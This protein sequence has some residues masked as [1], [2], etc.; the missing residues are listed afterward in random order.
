MGDGTYEADQP[1]GEVF[2]VSRLNREARYLLEAGFSSVRVEGELSN[3]AR[4]GSGHMYFTLKDQGA[5]LRCAMFRQNNQRLTFRPEDGQA[6]VCR[7]RLSI[8]E[9]RGEYQ[10][11]VEAMAQAGEGDLQREFERLKKKLAAEGLFAEARK[12][13]PPPLPSRIGVITSPTGAAVRDILH[14]L[15][16]RFPAV[17]VRIYPVPVQGEGAAARIVAA[18]RNAGRRADCDVLILARGGGSM[19]DLWAFNEEILARAVYDSPIP[20]ITGIGHEIDFTIADFVADLRAPTPSGAAELAVPDGAEWLR[21][22]EVLES[23]LRALVARALADRGQKLG[24]T[25][26]RLRRLHP[27]NRLRQQAQRLDELE[28]RLGLACRGRIRHLRT[29]LA[30]LAGEFKAASPRPMIRAAQERLHTTEGR[31][32]SATRRAI[33]RY[34]GR[35]EVLAKTLQ[36]VGPEA[37]LERGYAIV[38]LPGDQIVRDRS[39]VSVGQDVSVRVAVGRFSARVTDDDQERS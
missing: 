15:A 24:W 30:A 1:G 17:P 16:R 32:R 28:Q 3:L 11:I 31:L 36:A 37:T 29:H 39:Q 9:M 27:G 25:A 13:R 4:P 34:Q 5:Q 21:R 35:L 2:T 18:V 8:Y 20:I 19:E 33:E 12:R 6:V 38:T 7:G 10:L 23:R 22:Y 26:Q 14:V